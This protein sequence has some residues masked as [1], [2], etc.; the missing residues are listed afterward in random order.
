MLTFS[1]FLLEVA[2]TKSVSSDDKGKLHELLLA[3]YL[4]PKKELPEHHRAESENADHAGT[5]HQVHDKLKK[6][7]GENAY[8]EIDRHAH[9]SAVALLKHLIETGAIK[10]GE[11]VGNVHW[12]SNRDTAKKHGDHYKTTGMLDPNSNADLIITKHD[13][14]G[15]VTGYHGVSAKYG[16]VKAPNYKNAGLATLEKDAKLKP[17][18]LKAIH[19]K[20]TE[21]VERMGYRGTTA[22]KHIQYKHDRDSSDPHEKKRANAAESSSLNHR[23]EIAKTFAHGLSKLSDKQLR[24]LIKNNVAAKTVI[25]HTVVHSHVQDDGTAKSVIH[26]PDDHVIHHLSQFKDLHVKHQGTS[27][28]IYGTKENGKIGRVATQSFKGTSGPNKGFVGTFGLK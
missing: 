5:P 8:H 23:T 24:E 18:T 9:Q 17:G 19:D 3:K 26:N 2:H 25:Q 15:N 10:E 4:N 21:S 28:V 11:H 1:E 22:Q 6:K 12:T 7:I 27:A 13:K 14:H 20:H 16:A